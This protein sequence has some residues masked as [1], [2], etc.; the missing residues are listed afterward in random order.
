MQLL[1]MHEIE[2]EEV[3]ELMPGAGPILEGLLA[4]DVREVAGEAQ[5]VMVGVEEG[6]RG[7]KE[8]EER[9]A[10]AMDGWDEDTVRMEVRWLREKLGEM[11]G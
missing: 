2:R 5:R 10:G 4:R 7:V 6:L 1:G 8:V 11:D 3:L 9:F